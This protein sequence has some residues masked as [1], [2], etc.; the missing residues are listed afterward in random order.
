MYED[1]MSCR[2]CFEDD[3]VE[4]EVHVFE[5]CISFK[6]EMQVANNIKFNQIFGTLEQQIHA[7]KFFMPIITKRDILLELSKDS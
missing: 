4:D 1:D 3:S 2:S 7:I 5:Q 6:E